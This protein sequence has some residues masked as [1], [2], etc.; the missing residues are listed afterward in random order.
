MLI[1][2]GCSPD[3]SGPLTEVASCEPT[4]TR[5]TFV[6]AT[7]NIHS[8]VGKDGT[9]DLLRTAKI[10]KGADFVGLQEVD[11]D[12]WRSGLANQV[13]LIADVLDHSYWEHV[14]AENYGLFG[15][16]GT[17]AST[18]LPVVQSGSFDLPVV[19][20]KPLR[21]LN[22]VKFLVDCRPVHAFVI[23]V[24]RTGDSSDAMQWEQVR[25]ALSVMAR[26][27]GN[28]PE[29]HIL[30]GDF[31]AGPDSLVIARLREQLVDV[32]SAKTAQT[33]AS[34]RIDYIFV[35]A[36]QEVVAAREVN[37]EASDHPAVIATLR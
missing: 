34:S 20:D 18:S 12:R 6:V 13:R 9:R 21:R 28:P 1:L 11:R 8:G 10:L 25:A 2:I 26:Q 33:P 14:P 4:G 37:D 15:S 7:Y 3:T 30:M 27:I 22:W 29:R 16:Y 17:A 32:L 5:P 23:H 19:A 35:S 24:T 31:N 36:D